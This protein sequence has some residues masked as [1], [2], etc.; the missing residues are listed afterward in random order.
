MVNL[1]RAL[2]F[3]ISSGNGHSYKLMLDSHVN[4]IKLIKKTT[5][6]ISRLVDGHDS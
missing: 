2:P 5:H 4:L 1:E 3:K 6:C